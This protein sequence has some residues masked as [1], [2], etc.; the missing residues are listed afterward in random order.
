MLVTSK[1]VEGVSFFHLEDR[2]YR[3]NKF[4]AAF[5]GRIDQISTHEIEVW[6][7][8]LG[9]SGR[10]RNNYRNAVL[11][12]FRYARAGAIEARRRGRS[13]NAFDVVLRPPL[14]FVR[15]YLWQ[16]GVLDGA[17]GAVLCSLAAA[18]VFVKYADLWAGP[19]ADREPNPV[20][21]ATVAT[22]R[23]DPPSEPPA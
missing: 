20:S 10:T 3:M 21:H 5:P 8:G 15:M 18:Q 13:A 16:L 22:P 19:D 1:R 4:A 7:N 23:G 11:Q 9:I 2:K 17:H 6:L 12:L 14:R